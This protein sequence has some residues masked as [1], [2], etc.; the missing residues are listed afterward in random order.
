M[1]LNSV[2]LADN[3]ES[4]DI[5]D[6][7]VLLKNSTV[8][9]LEHFS[10][11]SDWNLDYRICLSDSTTRSNL[12][13]KLSDVN[14]NNFLCFWYGHGKKDSFYVDNEPI[15]TTIENHYIF[16]NALIYTFSCYNG[17]ELADVLVKNNCK[18]F[19][20]YTSAANCPYGI[21]DMTSEIAMSFINSFL[22]GKSV[23]E[24]KEDLVNSYE[25]AIFDE[26]LEPFQRVSYQRNRD[27]LVVKG[28][29]KLCINDML[30]D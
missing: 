22:S 5:A 25:R 1:K 30:I 27:S 18:V 23:V 4:C 26:E 9:L 21:D 17:E 19:V 7:C 13:D 6:L 3:S 29:G 2:I 12:S 14:C 20:G 24:S 11:C 8:Q 15:I 16:S 10:C 28:D